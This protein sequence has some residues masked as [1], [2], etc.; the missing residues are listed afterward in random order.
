LATIKFC[1]ACS[2]CGRKISEYVD[3]L[4]V[5]VTISP[6]CP[7]CTARFAH[8][9]IR[10]GNGHKCADCQQISAVYFDGVPMCRV[11]DQLVD[12]TA[13]VAQTLRLANGLQGPEWNH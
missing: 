2:D 10:N 4:S 12:C 13:A 9:V 8:E 7:D 11:C 1:Y 3:A 5:L 6:R